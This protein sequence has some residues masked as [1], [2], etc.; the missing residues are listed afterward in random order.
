MNNIYPNN[1]NR[2]IF[3]SKDKS[4]YSSLENKAIDTCRNLI[5]PKYIHTVFNRFN[6]GYMYKDDNGEIIG[7]CLWKEYNKI[8]KSGNESKQLHILLI[9]ADYNDYNLGRKILYD[10]DGYC[11]DN[12]ISSII[13]EA[14]NDTLVKYYEKSGFV[15]LNKLTREMYKKVKILTIYKNKSSSKTRKIKRQSIQPKDYELEESF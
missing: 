13:L 3:F 2:T 8:T 4:R 5:S 10:M 6:K 14:A 9:C 7:F 11:I 15:L 1:I 12:K